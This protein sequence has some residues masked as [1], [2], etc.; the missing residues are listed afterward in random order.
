MI[1]VIVPVSGPAFVSQIAAIQK[2]SEL[3]IVPE[4]IL[5]SSGGNVAAYVGI[6]GNWKWNLVELFTQKI[7]SGLLFS[8]WSSVSSISLVLGYFKGDVYNRGIGVKKLLEENVDPAVLS[9]CEIWTGTYNKDTEKGRIFCNLNKES[10][11]LDEKYIDHELYQLMPC[12]YLGGNI[13]KISEVCVAS[14]TIPSLVPPQKIDEH[15]YVD[16]GVSSSSPLPFMTEAIKHRIDTTNESLHLFQLSCCDLESQKDLLRR[17]NCEGK[18]N[19]ILDNLL[20]LSNSFVRSQALMDRAKALD[21]IKCKGKVHMKSFSSIRK[22]DKVIKINELVKYSMI[23]IYPRE[24]VQV[25][26][27]C[28]TGE[29]SV[30][31]MKKSAKILRF[32]VWWVYPEDKKE[33]IDKLLDC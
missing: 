25:K 32:R 16:G 33:E 4:V 27:T 30:R 24:R 18:E 14:A 31:M 29:D 15:Y 23:E 17:S 13:E 12:G 1:L 22:L 7:N 2:L 19:N 6:C 3:K 8:N 9:A 26:M 20:N 11:V 5:S 28:F 21:L 10:C